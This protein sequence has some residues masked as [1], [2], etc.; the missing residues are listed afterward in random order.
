LIGVH[1]SIEGS[2]PGWHDITSIDDLRNAVG[3]T[4]GE[5]EAAMLKVVEAVNLDPD[6]FGLPYIAEDNALVV[7]YVDEAARAAL[8]ERVTPGV[9]VRWER[10]TYT[11]SELKRIAMEISDLRLDGVFGIS[12]GTSENR[13]I[14]MVGPGGSVEEVSAVLTPRYGGAVRVEFSTD[15]PYVGG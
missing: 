3:Y 8:E 11:Q 10:V 1:E 15:I 4:S 12:S 9:T 14:V 5:R 13:V 7:Q 6:H 2:P